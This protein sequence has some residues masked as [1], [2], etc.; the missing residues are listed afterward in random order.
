MNVKLL[1]GFLLLM[2]TCLDEVGNKDLNGVR[3]L[4][5]AVAGKKRMSNQ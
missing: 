3:V 1:Y 4:I 2:L 5:D